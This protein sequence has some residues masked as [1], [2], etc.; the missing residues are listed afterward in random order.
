MLIAT[1]MTKIAEVALLKTSAMALLA[2]VSI[3]VV[4]TITVFLTMARLLAPLILPRLP[5]AHLAGISRIARHAKRL[6]I[7]RGAMTRVPQVILDSPATRDQD[8]AI[9]VSQLLAALLP[10]RCPLAL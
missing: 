6:P 2:L 8:A 10:W 5:P 3:A 7:A 9:M 1:S 4:L